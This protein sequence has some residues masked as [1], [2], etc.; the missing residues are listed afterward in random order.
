MGKVQTIREVLGISSGV[1]AKLCGSCRYDVIDDYTQRWVAWLESQ[2]DN[3]RFDT[4]QDA[5]FAFSGQ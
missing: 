2:P 1:V 3:V 5:Y 4:W